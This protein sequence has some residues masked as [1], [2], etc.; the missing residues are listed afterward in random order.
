MFERVARS[1][2][3]VFRTGD[4]VSAARECSLTREL[5]DFDGPV[6]DSENNDDSI[7]G[8]SL[9][10]PELVPRITGDWRFGDGGVHRF[11]EASVN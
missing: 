6:T 11:S 7:A 1:G 2:V 10:P 9:G 4:L 5:E 8:T 3:E